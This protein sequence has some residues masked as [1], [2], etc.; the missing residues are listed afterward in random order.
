MRQVLGPG[1]L[2]RPRGIG[3]R[4]RGEGGSG[5]GNTCNSMADSCQGMTNSPPPQKEE[6]LKASPI[7]FK[8]IKGPH[9]GKTLEIQFCANIPDSPLL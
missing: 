8:A 6:G 1:A 9:L 3:W 2:G 4:E 7:Y 5:W